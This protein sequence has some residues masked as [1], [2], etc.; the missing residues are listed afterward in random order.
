MVVEI[1]DI[2]Y[3]INDKNKFEGSARWTWISTRFQSNPSNRWWD[4]SVPCMAKNYAKMP[5]LHRSTLYHMT[6]WIYWSHTFCS[7]V[8][9]ASFFWLLGH[10]DS[11]WWSSISSQSYELFW[12]VL[13]ARNTVWMSKQQS[14]VTRTHKNMF[15]D[16]SQNFQGIKIRHADDPDF[17]SVTHSSCRAT[18]V[19][20][21][22]RA[23]RVVGGLTHGA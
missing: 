14:E 9:T 21:V 6:Y 22:V 13:M 8:Y 4:I 20:G 2:W 10:Q 12:K 1:F 16:F 11:S 15:L 23:A 7:P 3:M 19:C 18:G 5:T 17:M